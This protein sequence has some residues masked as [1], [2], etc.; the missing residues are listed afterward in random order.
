LFL[1]ELPTA[2]VGEQAVNAAS[3][4]PQMEAYRRRTCWLA[5]YLF[6]RQRDGSLLDITGRLQQSM[7]RW[8]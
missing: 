8:R 7:R 4:V 2:G 5:P 6:R 1:A 3:D